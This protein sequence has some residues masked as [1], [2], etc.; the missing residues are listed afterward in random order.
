M[1]LTLLQPGQSGSGKTGTGKYPL[2]RTLAAAMVAATIGCTPSS[3]PTV[4]IEPND[5]APARDG[6]TL[7]VAQK[8]GPDYLDPALS[9]KASGWEPLWV[10][11]TPLLTYKHAPGAEGTRPIPGLA[12]ALP[13]VSKDG[14]TYT[15]K[16]RKGLVYSDGTAVKASDFGHTIYRMLRLASQGAANF[17]DI[18]GVSAIIEENKKLEGEWKLTKVS[19]IAADDATG[20]IK[21]TLT[22]SNVMFPYIM[23]M[24][25][26]GLVPSSTPIK[27]LTTAPPPGVGAFKITKHDPRRE[28]VL[29]RNDRFDVPGLPKAQ[30]DKIVC[31]IIDN[32]VQMTQDVMAD[33]LDYMFEPPAVSLRQRVR[34]E[35]RG[36]YTEHV[37]PSTHF[38]CMNSAVPPFSD[39]RVRQA[40]GLAIDRDKIASLYGGLLQPGKTFIPP[41]IPGH[42]PA[43]KADKPKL[44]QARKLI[45]AAGVAGAEV[46]V[47]GTRDDPSKAVSEYLTGVLNELGLKAR[48][49]AENADQYYVVLGNKAKMQKTAFVGYNTWFMDYPHPGNFFFLVHGRTIQDEGNQNP[50][51]V[52][53]DKINKEYDR[54]VALPEPNEKEWAALDRYLV[55]ETAYVVPFGSVKYT[56]FLSKRM[57]AGAAYYHLIYQNDYTSFVTKK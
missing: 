53:D 56:T 19:G 51:M 1:S 55:E 43:V 17:E 45:Q 31:R 38:F 20:V 2:L 29:E 33:R 24:P 30:V 14:R 23:A 28:F 3:G 15:F 44:L 10:C 25:F 18:E 35:C 42:D 47:F 48:F 6:L 32:D 11:Y 49:Q 46:V 57:D 36:R 7:L 5:P 27:N 22:K 34:D 21:I 41:G 37:T 12:E 40:V 9:Y 39:A 4:A 8:S 54:L 52:S 26:A 13:E 16:L 50:G